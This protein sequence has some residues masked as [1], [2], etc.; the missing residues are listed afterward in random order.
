MNNIKCIVGVILVSILLSCQ[1]KET[2]NLEKEIPKERTQIEMITSKGTIKLALYNET[3]QHRDNFIKIVKDGVLDSVLFHRVI[4]QFMIQAGDIKSK[5]ADSTITLGPNDLP[6]TVPAE[7]N[8]KLY[9]KRGALG[10]ARD[11]NPEKA[12]SSTQFYIVQR[13][14]R[15]DSLIDLDQERING[16]LAEHYMQK[17]S[18]Y[19]SLFEGRNAAIKEMDMDTYRIYADSL[20]ILSKDFTDY[21]KYVIPEDHREVYRT[22]GGT[23]HLD[24]NYTVFG[25]VLEGMHVVDSIAVTKTSDADRPV[26]DIRILSVKIIEK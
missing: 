13:G 9:H 11:G 10:A 8:Q 7:I 6:Y 2:R 5:N 18:L 20:R 14:P 23:P 19:S 24:Q 21:E 16:W 12:S 1:H 25:E 22:S 17:D 4:N 3:P 26:E 15:Q